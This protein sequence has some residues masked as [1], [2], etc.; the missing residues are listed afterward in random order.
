MIWRRENAMDAE[1]QDAIKRCALACL[2]GGQ[3]VITDWAEQDASRVVGA[4]LREAMDAEQWEFP[5]CNIWHSHGDDKP[6]CGSGL[7]LCKVRSGLAEDEA[8]YTLR[9]KS[10]RGMHFYYRHPGQYVKSDSHIKDA[11]GFVV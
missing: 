4:V 9:V 5:E 6:G 3:S 8:A 2:S 10:K 7:R 11:A 1:L